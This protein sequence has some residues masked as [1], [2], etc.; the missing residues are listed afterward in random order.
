MLPERHSQP[1]TDDL[2]LVIQW[3]DRPDAR[4]PWWVH[5]FYNHIHVQYLRLA[6]KYFRIPRAKQ[7]SVTADEQGHITTVF[8]WFENGGVYDTPDQADVAC[9]DEFDGYKPIPH[10]RCA[11]RESGEYETP[12]F[13]RAKKP[14]RWANRTMA[15]IW[16][17]RKK[18]EREQQQWKECLARLNKE[19]DL[20]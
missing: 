9:V 2:Y 17:D 8:S 12:I 4:E 16:K 3:K 11:G 15:L 5:W 7:V 20:R 13:P 10:N 18:D 14:R 1:N 19:L 6:F